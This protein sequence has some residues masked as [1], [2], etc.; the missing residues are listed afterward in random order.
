MKRLLIVLLAAL[1]VTF[2]TPIASSAQK[3]NPPSG[4]GGGGQTAAPRGGGQSG[5]QT[6]STPPSGGTAVRRGDSGG[7]GTYSGPAQARPSSGRP[8]SGIAVPRSTFPP[9]RIIVPSRYYGV[10]PWLYYSP[11]AY[12]AF[13]L[14][15]W[16]WDPYWWGWGMYPNYWGYP[17]GYGGYYGGYGGYYG[18]GYSRYDRDYYYRDYGSLRLKV[19]PR[20]AEVYVDGYYMGQVDDFDGTFQH[21]DLDEGAH[22]IE[23]RA[24]G[25][26]PLVFE[27]RVAPGR[28]TTYRGE[29]RPSSEPR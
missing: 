21:L 2:A 17:Y 15:Y 25:F 5:G 3:R 28:T 13:G 8:V 6:H 16:G 11:Y 19:K 18:G 10:S 27:M 12:G 22:R 26:Q 4:G 29:L 9:T 23:I 7:S 24:S 20:N 1:A 14:G